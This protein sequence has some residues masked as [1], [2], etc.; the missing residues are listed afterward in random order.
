VAKSSVELV[1]RVFAD[2]TGV[3]N[4]NVSFRAL[5]GENVPRGLEAAGEPF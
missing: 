3:E 1:A 5:A 4:D 2:G